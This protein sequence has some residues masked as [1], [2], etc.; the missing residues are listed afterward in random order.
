MPPLY[1][2][3]NGYRYF[4]TTN[5]SRLEQVLVKFTSRLQKGKLN[6][7]YDGV[8]MRRF[9]RR[10]Q[11]STHLPGILCPTSGWNISFVIAQILLASSFQW[12]SILFWIFTLGMSNKSNSGRKFGR[13]KGLHCYIVNTL[14]CFGWHFKMYFTHYLLN[15]WCNFETH[16]VSHQ[17]LLSEM[18]EMVC[19]FIQQQQQQQKVS[20]SEHWINE[21][22][23]K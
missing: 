3:L 17:F 2:C 16:R 11:L 1:L 18:I 14:L 8:K 5:F 19:P 7:K 15:L 20:L 13:R 22:T 9:P 23:K 10:I 21:Q 12:F 6:A 4:E